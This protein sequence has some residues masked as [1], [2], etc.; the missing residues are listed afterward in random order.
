MWQALCGETE[1]TG[2]PRRP[3]RFPSRHGEIKSFDP[4]RKCVDNMVRSLL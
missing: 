1:Q 2:G 4:G 3:M